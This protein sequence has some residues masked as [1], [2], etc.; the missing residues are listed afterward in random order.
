MD[1]K[2]EQEKFVG[3]KREGINIGSVMTNGRM[4]SEQCATYDIRWRITLDAA[5]GTAGP[6]NRPEPMVLGPSCRYARASANR[7]MFWN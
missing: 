5:I 4:R 7:R 2:L 1:K 6:R 3:W